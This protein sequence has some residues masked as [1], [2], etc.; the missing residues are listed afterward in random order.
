MFL[1]KI[2]TI[3]RDYDFTF[4]ILVLGDSGVGKTCLIK[5]FTDDD[6]SENFLSTIGL[7][8]TDDFSYT[9]LVLSPFSAT[10]FFFL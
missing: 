5:R 1:A 2:M 10:R 6:F 9:N 7:Y 3:P 8:N 4:K